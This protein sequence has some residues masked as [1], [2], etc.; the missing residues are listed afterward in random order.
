M[1]G[2]IL[3]GLEDVDKYYSELLIRVYHTYEY[4]LSQKSLGTKQRWWLRVQVSS[5]LSNKLSSL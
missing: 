4:N 5:K 2:G 1:P 3:L